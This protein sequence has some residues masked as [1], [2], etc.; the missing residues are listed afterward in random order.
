MH[1]EIRALKRA[2]HELRMQNMKDFE[3]ILTK[4]QLKELKK[5]KEEGR[6]KFEK[7]HK[8]NGHPQ[9]GPRPEGP[10]PEGPCPPPAPEPADK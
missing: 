5:M 10:R 7:Q 3:G 6:K 9:F 4:K 8:K 2:A 1:K